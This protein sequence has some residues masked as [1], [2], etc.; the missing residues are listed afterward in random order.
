MKVKDFIE[1]H[2]LNEIFKSALNESD[3]ELPY[4]LLPIINEKQQIDEEYANFYNMLQNLQPD[5]NIEGKITVT[6]FFDII[7]DCDNSRNE[8][9]EFLSWEE[10]L[11]LDV[12]IS[13]EPSFFELL[14]FISEFL[15]RITMYGK[16]FDRE[17]KNRL[18]H[19]EKIKESLIP[20]MN[21]V[22][23]KIIKAVRE[24]T[25]IFNSFAG[26]VLFA[27][28]LITLILI[29]A[30]YSFFFADIFASLIDISL[31]TLLIKILLILAAF[32]IFRSIIW[33][34]DWADNYLYQN[35]KTKLKE[36]IE[37][38]LKQHPEATSFLSTEHFESLDCYFSR[39]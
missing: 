17:T 14:F 29:L 35:F 27:G 25:S 1:K 30:R 2:Q 13:E 20:K 16:A 32:V 31:D 37:N 4:L 22:K 36:N 34:Y 23:E 24:I 8:R 21:S 18:I 9:L 19:E 28:G 12:I 15:Y 26:T 10:V 38:Y 3:G 5:R 6:F 11:A 7:L 39:L 33:L